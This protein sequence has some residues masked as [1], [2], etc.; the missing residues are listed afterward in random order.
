[1]Q[2]ATGATG[3]TGLTGPTGATGPA[4]AK[5]DT[6]L[7]GPA[8]ATGATG[9][10]GLTG[11]TGPTGA[12]GAQGIKGDTGL[13]GPAGATGATGL[14]GAQ[15]LQGAKG[16]TGATGSAG[17][18][19]PTGATGAQGI[20]GDT[21]AT[22]ATG[23]EGPSKVVTI[24]LPSWTLSSSSAGTS[25]TSAAFGTL[26]TGSYQFEIVISG[27]TA[28]NASLSS[29]LG[30]T[31]QSSDASASLVYDYAYGTGI[32]TSNGS[33]YFPKYSFTIVGTIQ[34]ASAN[35]NLSITVTDQTTYSGGQPLTFGGRA[36][37]Q[38]VG[39]IG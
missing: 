23:P 36:L 1:L 14:T 9:P 34:V 33:D 28:G 24:S 12:T 17:P 11:P 26:Q 21:G 15:G 18:A 35:T 30:L 37:I 10:T 7:T 19:G 3:S 27:R 20:K 6:G 39:S 38:F 31:L 4:G 32:S 2:G 13:S 8:G 22:G 16:D 29:R 5:G 25:S